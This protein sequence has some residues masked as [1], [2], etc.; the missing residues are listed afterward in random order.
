MALRQQLKRLEE[1]LRG[2]L[3]SFVL[4]DDSRHYYDPT[5][6]ERFLHSMNCLRAQHDGKPFPEP[7]ETFKAITRARDRPPHLSR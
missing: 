1:A 3:E 4:E 5:S 2:T 7:P 6:G